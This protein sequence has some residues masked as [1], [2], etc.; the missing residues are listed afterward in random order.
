MDANWIAMSSMLGRFGFLSLYI[1]SRQ[2]QTG[3]NNHHFRPSPVERK[4]RRVIKKYSIH[5]N[6]TSGNAMAF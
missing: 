4:K 3:T 1:P 6:T 2:Q 5:P